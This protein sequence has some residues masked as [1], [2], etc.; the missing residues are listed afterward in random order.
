MT[1]RRIS[2]GCTAVLVLLLGACGDDGTA[3]S[4]TVASGPTT[5]V[6]TAGPTTSSD[7]ATTETT[8]APSTSEIT[9][10]GETTV[11]AGPVVALW[12]SSGVVFPTPDEAAADFVE[13][14]LGVPPLLGDFMAGD[15]RSG[16]IV[17]YSPGAPE[18]ERATLL[19]RQLGTDDGWF[20]TSA[21]GDLVSLSTPTQ[22][23]SVTAGALLVE[24]IGHGF[25]AAIS[26]SALVA[27]LGA[28]EPPLVLDVEY[29]QAGTMEEPGPFSVT[30]D[31]SGAAPG[32][33]VA[34]VLR[35][36]VGLETDPGELAALAVLVA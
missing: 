28:G 34:I 21:I 7:P 20:V 18:S 35:G 2:T 29:A 3:A 15:S 31:I 11:P 26:V 13:Q 24:G 23:A 32:D 6:T 30:L 9:I 25:E 5:V 22:G 17:L 8:A 36:G 10:P 16:E 12:P 33:V 27:P 1:R 4:T 19:L 14:V